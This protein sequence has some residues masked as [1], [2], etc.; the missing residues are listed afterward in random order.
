MHGSSV[1][2]MF[3]LKE[4]ILSWFILTLFVSWR[5]WTNTIHQTI[6]TNWYSIEFICFFIIIIQYEIVLKQP[7][8]QH[9]SNLEI[10]T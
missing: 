2:G 4:G 6:N 9:K 10:D 7:R 1:E 8:I 3:P 5:D